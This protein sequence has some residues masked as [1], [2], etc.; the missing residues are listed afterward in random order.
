MGEEPS[1]A[2]F[3][4]YGQVG[5]RELDKTLLVI[6]TVHEMR[7]ELETSIQLRLLSTNP[8][9]FEA[10]DSVLKERFSAHLKVSLYS[11]HQI[12]LIGGTNVVVIVVCQ[13][14]RGSGRDSVLFGVAL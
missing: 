5:M 8:V 9:L 4:A 11:T 3:T 2:A 1:V 6:R 12:L 13:V 10:S 14:E 7:P